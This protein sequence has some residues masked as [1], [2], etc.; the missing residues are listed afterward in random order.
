M[1]AD[2]IDPLLV[3]VRP[4]RQSVVTR[5]LLPAHAGVMVVQGA[6]VVF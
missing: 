1:V 3:C 2:N 5:W 4:V 6:A